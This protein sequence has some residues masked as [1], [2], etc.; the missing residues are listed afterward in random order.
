MFVVHFTCA[1]PKYS[2]CLSMKPDSHPV[3]SKGTIFITLLNMRSLG[4]AAA[5]LLVGGLGLQG[6]GKLGATL[7][8]HLVVP[9]MSDS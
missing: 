6:N 3:K 9:H 5:K 8:R 4:V 1:G 2:A 7:D